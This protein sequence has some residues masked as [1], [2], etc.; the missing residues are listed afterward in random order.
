MELKP[1]DLIIT[2]YRRQDDRGSNWLNKPDT[3]VRIVHLPTGAIA[4]CDTDLSVHRNKAEALR[5]LEIKVT[6]IEESNLMVGAKPGADE[7]TKVLRLKVALENLLREYIAGGESGDWGSW[8][9]H[10]QDQVIEAKAALALFPDQ[11]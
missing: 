6:D 11:P 10:E 8:N 9:P 5:L 3:G 2:T 4:M 1:D 7:Q